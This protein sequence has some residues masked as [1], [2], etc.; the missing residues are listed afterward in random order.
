[1]R[2][3]LTIVAV[4]GMVFGADCDTRTRENPFDPLNPETGGRPALLTAS[5]RD[6]FADLRWRDGGMIGI[7]AFGIYSGP[8]ADSLTFVVSIPKGYRLF[9]EVG[10]ENGT[11]Y[12]FAIG[13]QFDH[14]DQLLTAA[15]PVTPGPDVPWVLDSENPP[16]ALLAADGRTIVS[17]EAYGADPID[18]SV[19]PEPS[20]VWTVD[21]VNGRLRAYDENGRLSADFPGFRY[22]TR[23]SADLASGGVWLISFDTGTLERVDPH[24]RRTR[25]DTTLV[26]PLDVEASPLG[27]CWVSDAQGYV[28]RYAPDGSSVAVEGAVRPTRLSATDDN[29]VWVAD[30]LLGAALLVS[31]EGVI[32]RVEGLDGPFD[33]AAT[34]GGGCWI[35]DRTRIMLADRAGEILLTVGGF[36]GARDVAYNPRTEECWVADS[37]ADKI[38]RVDSSGDWV[39][40]LSSVTSPFAIEGIW[41]PPD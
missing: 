25:V 2:R 11:T 31:I 40:V 30:P 39:T 5:A 34:T 1:M 19:E 21:A 24:G 13:F 22:L 8:S 12:Y 23:V 3:A 10:L 32:A 36:T 6:G 37:I 33:V 41:A 18:L 27:G 14:G 29:K 9:R 7:E 35:A 4:L 17:R 28:R 26:M 20:F 38:V 15:E 16:L